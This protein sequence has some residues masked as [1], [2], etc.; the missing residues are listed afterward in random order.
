MNCSKIHISLGIY[1]TDPYILVD[2][3]IPS[4]RAKWTPHFTNTAKV[5]KETNY[6]LC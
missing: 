6:I 4:N 1:T 5:S 3:N 2:S